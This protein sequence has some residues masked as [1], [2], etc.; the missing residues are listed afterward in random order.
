MLF[1]NVKPFSNPR[2]FPMRKMLTVAVVLTVSMLAIVGCK[3]SG[4][5]GDTK[6]SVTGAR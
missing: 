6:T 1:N 2:R 4:E 5:I 3:A